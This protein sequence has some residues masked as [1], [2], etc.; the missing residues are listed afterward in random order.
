VPVLMYVEG[1]TALTDQGRAIPIG[2]THPGLASLAVRPAAG[3]GPSLVGGSVSGAPTSGSSPNEASDP[4]TLVGRMTAE[5]DLL[6]S[7]IHY[8]VE[9]ENRGPHEQRDNPGDELLMR[10]PPGVHLGRGR[11]P[12]RGSVVH[13]V[14]EGTFGWNGSLPPGERLRVSFVG[15]ILDLEPGLE[16]RAQGELRYDADGDGINESTGWTDDPT[17]PGEADPTAWSMPTT[18]VLASYAA[19]G[20]LLPLALLIGAGWLAR[21][22]WRARA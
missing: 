22:R 18:E 8:T 11:L 3:A 12:A 2:P 9:L 21:R 17:L 1:E 6:R 7:S 19:A 10:P 20:T 14:Q 13:H 5:V 4:A 16:I 15:M